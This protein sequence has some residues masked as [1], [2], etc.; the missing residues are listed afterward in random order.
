MQRAGIQDVQIIETPGHPSIYGRVSAQ[1]PKSPTVLIYGHYD[2]QPPDPLDRWIS[3]P[4]SPEIRDGKIFARGAADNKGGVF[5]AVT[6]VENMI[7]SGGPP[8]NLK[9]LFEGE[10]EMAS[11]NIESLIR[12]NS[13]ILRADLVVSVD[14]AGLEPDVPVLST[15]SKGIC[16]VEIEV[17]AA[18]TDLHSGLAGGLV[19]NPLHALSGIVASMKHPDGKVAISGFYDDVVPLS[20]QERDAFGKVPITEKDFLAST[21]APEL[22][23]ECDFTALERVF[24]RPTLDVNGMWGGFTGDGLK[25]VV[26]AKAYCKITCRLVSDQEP[27]KITDLVAQHVQTHTPKGV[28]SKVTP[29]KMG[30]KA[31]LLPL[32]HPAVG[33][34]VRALREVYGREPVIMRSGGTLPVSRVFLDVL[35]AYLVTFSTASADANV[36]A[37][38]EFFRVQEFEK[39][40][41]GLP[42]LLR[43]LAQVLCK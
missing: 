35:G 24:A 14:G 3:P 4:F 43:E 10:E 27:S 32:R 20:Q 23:G 33:A 5:A 16:G 9:F 40:R 11:P 30:V 2:V 26:P 17:T 15:G 31:Y 8:L 21:G 22:F 41:Q 6:A 25:T 18:S 19:H 13:E 34:Q 42:V 38:N 37:P 12:S 36:H 1:N 29:Y 28:F 7:A 39:L